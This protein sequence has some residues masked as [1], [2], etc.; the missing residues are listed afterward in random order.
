MDKYRMIIEGKFADA[1]SGS[2]MQV[3]DPGTGESGWHTAGCP[4][5]DHRAGWE[6]R[7]SAVIASGDRQDLVHGQFPECGA[8]MHLGFQIA[9]RPPDP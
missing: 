8:G 3:T 4:E 7:R 2:T 9:A 1:I 6:R 5:R